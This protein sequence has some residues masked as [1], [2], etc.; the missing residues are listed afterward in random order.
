MK[1]W[2]L[3]F[4][5]IATTVC[6]AQSAFQKVYQ[7]GYANDFTVLPNNSGY[8]I[9]GDIETNTNE[10]VGVMRID[11]NGNENW[12]RTYRDVI[13]FYSKG[14]FII[15]ADSNGYYIGGMVF[16][17]TTSNQENC[18]MKIDSSGAIRWVR[19]FGNAAEDDE[20]IS[21]ASAAHGFLLAGYTAGFGSGGDD[22]YVVSLDSIGNIIRSSVYG[23]AFNERAKKIIPVTDGAVLFSEES[24]ATGETDI[25]ILKID[26]SGQLTYSK[27][28]LLNGTQRIFDVFTTA[29]SGFMLVGNSTGLSSDTTN[30]ICIRLDSAYNIV[31]AKWLS[32]SA[33]TT[34][35]GKALS[36]GE[37]I[38]GGTDVRQ[39]NRGNVLI[40]KVDATGALI[41][42]EI[43][44]DS[45]GAS[46]NKV[47][48][49]NDSVLL[50][51][52]MFIISPDINPRI[53]L[54]KHQIGLNDFCNSLSGT[55]QL[56]DLIL[57][58]D[59]T[60]FAAQNV[61]TPE[62][63][64][65]VISTVQSVVS[66]NVCDLTSI[67]E[68]ESEPIEIYPNPTERNF[69]IRTDWKFETIT[70]FDINGSPVFTSKYA[71]EINTSLPSGIYYLKLTDKQKKVK[72]RKIMILNH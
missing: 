24:D 53:Y 2:I 43:A 47:K 18:F 56:N 49:L 54:L 3:S 21:W 11:Q 62:I 66:Q 10:R 69:T 37:F 39:F 7:F 35:C 46:I 67:S 55:L 9:T 23:T 28:I 50:A 60:V 59:T 32:G 40:Y 12:S 27:K 16:N 14:N 17:D 8:L 13:E 72:R 6:T 57:S 30:S 25:A 52:G 58:I 29:D 5:V 51:S 26:T 65:T 22:I 63:T 64:A 36:S 41:M 71:L 31:W 19:R 44:G 20:L 33:N 70:L 4:I 45:S 61:G 68:P 42:S 48:F 34:Y 1:K 38:F 15:P